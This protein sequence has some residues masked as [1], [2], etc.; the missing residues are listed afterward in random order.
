M[1]C[2]GALSTSYNNTP[3]KASP[4]DDAAARAGEKPIEYINTHSTSMP[5]GDLAELGVIKRL[6]ERKGYQPSVGSTKSL[7]GHALGAA[8]VHE[9]IYTILMIVIGHGIGGKHI[10]AKMARL[11]ESQSL[12]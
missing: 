7:S 11:A 8:G 1:Q 5:V 3:K 10:P 4:R 9:T 12:E 6:F 2:M